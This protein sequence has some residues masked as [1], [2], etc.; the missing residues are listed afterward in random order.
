MRFEKGQSG[1]PSGRPIGAKNKKNTLLA[2]RLRDIVENNIEAIQNDIDLLPPGERIKAISALLPY[3]LPKQQAVSIDAQLNA[4][5]KILQNL[6]ETAPNEYVEKIAER[7]LYL[8]D[9]GLDITKN[10][11]PSIQVIFDEGAKERII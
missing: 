1:N 11:V 3:V 4:E 7:V 5:Y 2:D 9:N 8:S 10:D 6:I